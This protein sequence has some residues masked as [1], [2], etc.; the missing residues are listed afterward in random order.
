GELCLWETTS[1]ARVARF[2]VPGSLH[3]LAFDPEGTRLALAGMDGT[4]LVREVTGAERWRASRHTDAVTSLAFSPDGRRLA[5]A[6]WD[7]TVRLWDAR[8]GKE[9]HLLRGPG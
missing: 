4:V 9:L 7:G 2:E 6:G 1:G 5:S 8:T 3:Q